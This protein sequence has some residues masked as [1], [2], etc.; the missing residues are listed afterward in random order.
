MP[1][2]LDISSIAGAAS[3]LRAVASDKR[4]LLMLMLLEGSYSVGDLA[5]TSGIG[6]PTLSQQLGVLR[7]AGL[8]RST[9]AGKR[10]HYILTKMARER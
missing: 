5:V 4:L 6:Q 10:N 2:Q 8:I 9:R 3:D 7:K 1:K